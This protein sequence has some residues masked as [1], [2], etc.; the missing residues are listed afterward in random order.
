MKIAYLPGKTKKPQPSLGGAFIRHRPITAVR[1]SGPAGSW[2]LDGLLDTGSDDTVFPEWVATAVGLDLNVAVD[3]D[4]HLA[5]RA[6]PLRC[7][8]LTSKLRITDGKRETFEW[9]AIVGFVAVPLKCPLL[10]Q[11]G[12]LQY[13]NVTFQGADYIVD[14]SPNR[15][16]AGTQ[17]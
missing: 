5:G 13:F 6:S 11:A 10:G 8:Y 15:S 7:R 1:I 16:F 2:I 4:I 14:L 12:A 3:H 17:I 9:D